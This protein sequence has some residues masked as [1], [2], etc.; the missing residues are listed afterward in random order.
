MEPI[1]QPLSPA[2]A[3]NSKLPLILTGLVLIL[4]SGTGG[5]FLGKQFYSKPALQ[6]TP[7]LTLKTTPTPDPTTNWEVY[8]DSKLGYSIKYP[9]NTFTVK[10]TPGTGIG[11]NKGPLNGITI[12]FQILSR[13][14]EVDPEVALKRETPTCGD[15]A[16]ALS[17]TACNPITENFHVNN[18]VGIRVTSHSGLDYYL[19]DLNKSVPVVRIIIGINKN[20]PDFEIFNL[21]LSTFKFLD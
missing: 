8:T 10:A 12:D 6:P 19:T 20:D 17:P 15:A 21:I 3:L 4:V 9:K 13:G 16:K 14:P 2:P 7:S 1:P 18:A 11:I 5:F